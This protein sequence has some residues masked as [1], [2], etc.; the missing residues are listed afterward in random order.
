[1]YRTILSLKAG[2]EFFEH[3]I[4]P[5][6]DAPEFM[7]RF[8]VIRRVH[9]VLLK[10]NRIGNLAWHGPDIHNHAQFGQSRH[11]LLIKF[12]HTLSRQWH[13][14]HACLAR[15]DVVLAV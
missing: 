10:W 9:T 12:G 2:A 5:Y 8:R 1:M 7:N 3:L 14:D 15:R 11:E 4:D 13:C 6:H